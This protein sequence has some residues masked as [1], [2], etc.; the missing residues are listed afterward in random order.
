MEGSVKGKRS[1][2]RRKTSWL[3]NLKDLK[4]LG[5]HYACAKVRSNIA[6][7]SFQNFRYELNFL[8]PHYKLDSQKKSFQFYTSPTASRAVFHIWLVASIVLKPLLVIKIIKFMESKTNNSVSHV[9]YYVSGGYC[10][11]NSN[12]RACYGF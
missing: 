4:Q 11:S 12:F 2:G 8:G 1:Q 3:V 5:F 10:L 7:I 6:S 9:V